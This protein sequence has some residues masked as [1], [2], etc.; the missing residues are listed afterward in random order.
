M[1]MHSVFAEKLQACT[2]TASSSILRRTLRSTASRV[3]EEEGEVEEDVFTNVQN[4]QSDTFLAD[5]FS[6]IRVAIMT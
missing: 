4:M 1:Q 3:H 6:Y 5:A 2:C